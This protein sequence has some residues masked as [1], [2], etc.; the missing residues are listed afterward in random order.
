[1]G[2]CSEAIATVAGPIS[3]T[4]FCSILLLLSGVIAVRSPWR[5]LQAHD[6]AAVMLS[7]DHQ[8]NLL[9][10]VE[11]PQSAASILVGTGHP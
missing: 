9:L 8:L 7:P 3:L 11:S 1:M 6:V 10:F 5:E 2:G 4:V